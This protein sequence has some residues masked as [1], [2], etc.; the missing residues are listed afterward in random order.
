[1]SLWILTSANRCL[2]KFAKISFLLTFNFFFLTFYSTFTPF[3]FRLISFYSWRTF[4]I[5]P[6]LVKMSQSPK[7]ICKFHFTIVNALHEGLLGAKSWLNSWNGPSFNRGIQLFV[8]TLNFTYR[9][10]AAYL[11]TIHS[12]NLKP[13]PFPRIKGKLKLKKTQKY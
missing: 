6:T 12:F 1:M 3:I 10:L 8:T 2:L 5:P 9:L 4:P 7:T 11:S 13:K